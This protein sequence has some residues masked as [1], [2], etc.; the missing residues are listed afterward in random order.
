MANHVENSLAVKIVL[1]DGF[2]EH[3]VDSGMRL[4]RTDLIRIGNFDRIKED[5]RTL[6]NVWKEAED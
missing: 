6:I 1:S 3:V 5:L 2:S 4:T